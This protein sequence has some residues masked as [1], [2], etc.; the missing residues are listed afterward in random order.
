MAYIGTYYAIGS[1]WAFTV[2]NYF[3]IGF[4]NGSLDHYYID[5]FKVYFAIVFIFTILGNIS[6]AVVRYVYHTFHQPNPSNPSLEYQRRE[7]APY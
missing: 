7:F 6:L 5:S 1:A 4:F 3:L 2:M